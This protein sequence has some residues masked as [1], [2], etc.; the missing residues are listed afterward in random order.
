[1]RSDDVV[2]LLH[3]LSHADV[4]GKGGDLR[5]DTKVD[6]R[7]VGT[8][9]LVQRLRLPEFQLVQGDRLKRRK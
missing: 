9:E 2:V 4:V 5:R 1:M 6:D 8:I 3:A 7:H